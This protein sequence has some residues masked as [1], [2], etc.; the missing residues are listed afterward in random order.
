M[1]ML[2]ISIFIIPSMGMYVLPA[3]I[4]QNLKLG[5]VYD[6]PMYKS[7]QKSGSTMNNSGKY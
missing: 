2:F 1:A 6:L 4:E 7:E 5:E 3:S